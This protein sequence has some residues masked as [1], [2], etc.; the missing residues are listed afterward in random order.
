M[1]LLSIWIR[2]YSQEQ[3]QMIVVTRRRTSNTNLCTPS[4]VI[5]SAKLQRPFLPLPDDAKTRSVCEPKT[6]L[7][8]GNISKIYVFG[9]KL[10]VYSWFLFANILLYNLIIIIIISPLLREVF[11]SRVIPFSPLLNNNLCQT[12][13]FLVWKQQ[14]AFNRY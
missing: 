11:R 10:T 7:V 6:F 14:N 5:R 12:A 3:S 9:W 4:S 1:P 8:G 2:W 13:V